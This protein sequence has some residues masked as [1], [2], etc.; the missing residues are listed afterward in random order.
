MTLTY[1][2][3]KLIVFFKNRLFTD[4]ICWTILL[5][6]I[7]GT[8]TVDLWRQS[9]GVVDALGTPMSFSDFVN[10]TRIADANE[11]FLNAF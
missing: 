11:R 7:I 3:K 2:Q 8:L 6:L 4:L 5:L 9:E 1:T 10:E